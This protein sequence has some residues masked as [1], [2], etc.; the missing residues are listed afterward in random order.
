MTMS[1]TGVAALL[2]ARSLVTFL[3]ML[4]LVIFKELTL[5]F[6]QKSLET[7]TV[8]VFFFIDVKIST[9]WHEFKKSA[10]DLTTSMTHQMR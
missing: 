9:I 8:N 4:L 1:V 2:G 5:Q 3:S 7:I 10:L 6:S